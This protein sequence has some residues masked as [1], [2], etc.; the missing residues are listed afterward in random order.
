[1]Q[2][3][4]RA[5]KSGSTG[6][7]GRGGSGGSGGSGRE[8]QPNIDTSVDLENLPEV[9]FNHFDAMSPADLAKAAKKAK[10]SLDVDK[11][12]V[13]ESLLKEA[14]PDAVYRTGI[15]ELMNDG[16]GF[17]RRPTFGSSND[18][19]YV[20][21]NLVRKNGL[22]AGDT[23]MG[24]IRPPREGE[25]YAGM[26]RI[27]SVNGHGT[28]SPEHQSRRSFDELT[29]LFP[30]QRLKMETTPENI[31]GRIIDLIS[32]IG[33][34]SRGLIV[35]PPKAGKTTIVKTIANSITAN[36]PGVYLM[37]LLVDERPEEV[38]DMRRSVKGQVISSTFDEPA[39]NHM[40]VTDL[41]LEQAKRLVEA[42][43]DVVILLDSI[44]RLS[45]A[46][47]LTINPSGRTLSGGL[48]PAALYRPRRFFGA[49]RNIEEGGSLTIIATALIE[50]GSKMDDAIFEEFKGTGN[51]EI[52]LDRELAERRIWPAMDVRRSSTRHEE[53]LFEREA[54]EAVVQLHRILANTKDNVE[55]TD[56]LIKL[57]KRTPTNAAFLESVMARTRAT[58]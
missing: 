25:K 45:R 14:N 49:A 1:M 11:G 41:C 53:K 46:S 37:V 52:V 29:P 10:I 4:F 47:N 56:Q 28:Q 55:A 32:P 42:G 48:D 22:K 24:L 34:G 39:E 36:N 7:R 44:T 30:E 5:R 3:T 43:R 19:V 18:D 54:L 17:L 8:K 38:T 57:L 33:M 31:I 51:M 16:W 9:D 27:E 6:R 40:R 12:V 23:V 26:L 15:L 13:I 58:V 35:A 2:H 50:T 20:S 21:Q